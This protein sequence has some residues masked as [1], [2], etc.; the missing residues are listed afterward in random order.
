MAD[1]G[2]R[3]YLGCESTQGHSPKTRASFYRSHEGIQFLEKDFFF[4][5]LL[6]FN[7]KGHETHSLSFRFKVPEM[8]C[9]C[10]TIQV[11]KATR[12]EKE[13]EKKRKEKKKEKSEVRIKF[14]PFYFDFL[15]VIY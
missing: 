13:V 8:L 11:V 7:P 5:R 2:R 15:H 6:T 14:G 12:K 1:G 3:L 4:S 9:N 10:I